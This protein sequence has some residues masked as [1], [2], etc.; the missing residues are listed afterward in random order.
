MYSS[1]IDIDQQ[2]PEPMVV[3]RYPIG[4][5]S[6]MENKD[7]PNLI[8]HHRE[9]VRIVHVPKECIKEGVSIPNNPFVKEEKKT[10]EEL[11]PR[12]KKHRRWD[13]PRREQL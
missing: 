12:Q 10:K 2:D 1:G 8:H 13:K 9:E 4:Q 5:F 11:Q 3:H 7:M 6:G